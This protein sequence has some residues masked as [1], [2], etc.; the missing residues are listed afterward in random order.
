M[1]L[2]ASEMAMNSTEVTRLPSCTRSIWESLKKS[3]ILWRSRIYS[4]TMEMRKG[5]SELLL[6][7]FSKVGPVLYACGRLNLGR[8]SYLVCLLK[9]MG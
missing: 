3:R 7:L 9:D 1:N 2:G 8:D 6:S 5:T 4:M